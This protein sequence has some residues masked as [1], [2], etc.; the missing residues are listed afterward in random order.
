VLVDGAPVLYVPPRV[1]KLITFPAAADRE[2][3][4]AAAEALEQVAARRRG[5]YLR[6]DEIDGHAA[7]SS[8]LAEPLRA[9]G[10]RAAYRGLELES[11]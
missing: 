1:R 2:A 9:A 7:A 6:I 10:F 5:R 3:L 4:V 11:R 8:P